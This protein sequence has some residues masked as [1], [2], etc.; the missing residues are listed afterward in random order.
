MYTKLEQFFNKDLHQYISHTFDN[1]YRVFNVDYSFHI[2]EINHAVHDLKSV[3]SPVLQDF[4]SPDLNWV[5]LKLPDKVLGH[6]AGDCNYCDG[7]GILKECPECEGY[8]TVYLEND[9]NDYSIT[10]S[11]CEGVSMDN[12]TCI[13]CY[14]S[15]RGRFN[16]NLY[17]GVSGIDNYFRGKVHYMFKDFLLALSHEPNTKMAL[18]KKGNY[19]E[20]LIK[21]HNFLVRIA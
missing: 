9:F 2:Y 21:N 3:Y 17:F 13:K 14:G 7:E 5:D 12:M 18:Y 6:E 8:G 15:G 19:S 11:T 4:V 10:C 20:A 1:A 16:L